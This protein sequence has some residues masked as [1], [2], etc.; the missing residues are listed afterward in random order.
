MY[1]PQ[2]SAA[3][4]TI[5]PILVLDDLRGGEMHLSALFIGSA[6]TAPDPVKVGRLRVPASLLLSCGDRALWRARFRAPADATSAYVWRGERFDLKGGLDGD[7][8]IAFVSCNGEE[9]GDLDRAGEER[10]VMW[11]RLARQHEA[12]PFALL[13]HGGDQI[14]A[15]EATQGHPLSEDW[16]ADIPSDPSRADLAG[17]RRHLRRAF[18]A[19]YEAVYSTP[20][21]A[22]LCAR[23]PSLMQWDDHDI[24]DG[25]GS[26]SR[27]ATYSPVGQAIFDVAREMAL[28]FQHAARDGDLPGRFVDPEGLHLGWRIGMPGLRLLAPDLRSERTRRRIMGDGGW[29]MMETALGARFDGRT[30]L[31]SSVPLLGPR[32]SLLEGVMRLHPKMLRY[33]DDLRDQW[34]SRAH[35]DEWRRMLAL[36]RDMAAAGGTG[37]TSLSGEIHLA[38]RATMALGGGRDLHQLTASGI[39]HRAPPRGWA[40]FLGALSRLGDAPLPGHPI[41][42]RRL[43][44]QRGLFV[45][46]RNF[47][48]LSRR[49]DAWTA[50]WELEMSGS[51]EPLEI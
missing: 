48:V 41:R 16:P 44:G 19:R 1:R 30:L 21:M 26:L 13:F 43:S 40:W 28:G 20:A 23:V 50:R 37:I 46:E 29:S 3:P 12:T 27:S 10:N 6:A 8:R 36:L 11:A 4:G 18:F 14:Y 51:T 24:C 39:S 9:T 5:G 15:D 17:L 35:R 47:L 25:W 34:Q 42:M 49:G 32:L 33:E 45:A 2:T 22:R 31:M 38:A 7:M